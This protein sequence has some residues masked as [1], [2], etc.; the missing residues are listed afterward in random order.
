VAAVVDSI[1]EP[2]SLFGHSYGARVA[3]TAPDLVAGEIAWFLSA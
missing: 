1:H 2:T 3:M